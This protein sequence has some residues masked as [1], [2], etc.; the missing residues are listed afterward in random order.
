MENKQQQEELSMKFRRNGIPLGIA[1]F[2]LFAAL[3]FGC[4]SSGGVSRDGAKPLP[5]DRE[6]VSGSLENGLS[7]YVRKNSEPKNRIHLRLVVRAGSCMEDDDQCGVAHFVEHLAFNGTEHFEK[8]SLVD[9]FESI[10]MSFGADVNAYTSFEETVFMLEVPADDPSMLEKGMLVLRDWACGIT[11]GQDEIDKERGVVTEEWRLRRGLSGRIS[12]QLFPFLLKDSR[13]AERLPIG[14]MDVIKNVSRERIVDFYK[15]WYRPEFMSVVLVGDAEPDVLINAVK[16]VMSD[17]P[18]SAEKLEH[19]EF[20]VPDRTEKASL[21]MTDREMSYPVLEILAPAAVEPSTTE[22]HLREYIVSS[23]A[24]GILNERLSEITNDA[25]SP[26]VAANS[27][28]QR[29]VKSKAFNGV[30]FVPK[31]NMF[32]PAFARMLD[33]YERIMRFGV[34]ATEVERGKQ[35]LMAEM[36]QTYRSRDSI[37]SASYISDIV[38]YITGGSVPVSVGA[39]YQL[40][41]KILPT[42]TA[43][44]VLRSINDTIPDRGLMM[45]VESPE[46][47]TDMPSE[48][49]L[50]EIWK[51][52]RSEGL[53]AYQDNVADGK[54]GSRPEKSA[55]VVSSAKNDVLGVTEYVLENGLKV[56]IKRTDFEKN[57]ILFSMTGA[58]GAS[59]YDSADFYSAAYS[60]SYAMCSGI[61]GMTYPQ[62]QKALAGMEISLNIDVGRY[63]QSVSGSAPS[64]N[65]E[66]LLSL[67]REF[68]VAPQFNDTGWT[69]MKS[70][71]DERAKG[72]GAEPYDVFID[73]IN[74]IVFGG[75]F[76][77]R[78]LTPEV[79]A[80]LDK[81]VSERIYRERFANAAD[82]TAVFVGDID[83]KKL[84][85][86]CRTYLGTL[87]SDLS[88]LGS[89]VFKEPEFPKGNPRGIVRKGLDKQSAV[90][91]AFGGAVP[92]ESD[93]IK[94]WVMSE[95]M[96]PFGDMLEIKLR[97]EIREA[98]G[99]TYG[100]SVYPRI[101]GTGELDSPLSFRTEIS[102]GCEPGRET[103]LSDAVIEVLRGLAENPVD[104]ETLLKL[105]EQYRRG[106]ETSLRSNSWWLSE[107]QLVYGKSG[108]PASLLN[109]FDTIPAQFT[110]ENMQ[111]LVKKYCPVDDYVR[112]I[113]E[114]EQ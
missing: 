106:K 4:A 42:V 70:S 91:I 73:R 41:R 47:R 32:I 64:Q 49:E 71:L 18:A 97:N 48:K 44:D 82:F 22:W 27:V 52:Y 101:Y 46:S 37:K 62:M 69:I 12:D 113:L 24:S 38:E 68:L 78:S 36:E 61:A 19:P 10:G 43:D 65:L 80:S 23:I 66:N 53:A 17:I 67:A 112:V 77:F 83:E 5:F 84:V 74:E 85:G 9:Y 105:R 89:P 109:D 45:L 20:S 104:E 29:I 93:P 60:P 11:F 100:I 55:A 98:K 31:E 7:W 76:T 114:P 34:S 59:L 16:N 94:H 40:Y 108:E 96:L 28:H 39:Y 111:S 13:Y 102:F 86:L 58:G 79:A 33:E 72:H 14:D 26:W 30:A 51:N 87:P 56:I 3:V 6:I 103:E 63:R 2:F 110:G 1:A 25:G 81:A 50:V 95:T 54:I 90:Y 21:V 88:S 57:K 35:R 99:G 75:D 8:N 92:A 107:L 15:K